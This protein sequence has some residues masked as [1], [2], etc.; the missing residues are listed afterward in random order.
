[1]SSVQVSELPIETEAAPARPTGRVFFTVFPSIVLPMFLA[2]M[3]GTIVATALPAI[4]ASLGE[5]ERVSWV[6][7][8]YLVAA[9]IA[10]PVYG[11]LGDVIGRRRM[12]IMALGISVL[13]YGLCAI[14]TSLTMLV[15][16]RVLLGLGGGGLMTLSQAM[17][18]EVVPP[19]E[20]AKYQ[21]YMASVFVSASMFG[22]VVGGWLTQ[23]WGWRSVFMIG[24]PMAILAILLALR[25]PRR[26]TPAGSLHFD[27]LGTL[28]FAG[29]IAPALM[30]LKQAQSFDRAA[31][32]MLAGLLAI[33]VCSL[34]LLLRQ[35][36][37]ASAPLLPIAL[38]RQSSVWRADTL[39]ACI[40]AV[41]VSL[42][43]FLPLYFQVVRGAG[44]GQAG[45]MML[46][47]TCL[48][49]AGS[50]TTGRIISRTGRTASIPS[51]GMPMVALLL[52]VMALLGPSMSLMQIPIL[53]GVIALFNGTG[54]PVVQ[55]T[56][57]MLAGPRQLG[58]GAASVQFSR[59]VG[60]AIGTAVVGAVLFA[61][62]AASD[63]EAAAMFG[64]I[65]Q[66]GPQALDGL[67]VARVAVIQ[68]EIADAFRLAFLTIAGFA[69]GAAA[70]AWSIPMRRIG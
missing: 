11:R 53:L 20:R 50:L 7:V 26:S 15:A 25:L 10:A 44:P 38:L 31:L 69:M 41:L 52:V 29:F 37:R 3:D 67:P 48:I 59:T 18:G 66:L 51:V 65:V 64:R 63:P 2:A 17:V 13:A 19:R 14:A 33:A 9:T 55:V 42:I 45:M 47:L 56:V 4:A 8:A 5:V 70:M 32:P 58:A 6:V 36:R 12:L 16:A 1:M 28:F 49:A 30:A 46:P 54:M 35:E 68:Q 24:P 23:H 27:Y 39:A 60:A 43:T 21:G 61:A 22:P 57:Q 62:L 40:G 34:M